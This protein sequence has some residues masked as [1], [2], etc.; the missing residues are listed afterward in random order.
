MGDGP[1]ADLPFGLDGYAGYVDASGIGVTFPAVVAKYPGA[2]HLSIATHGKLAMCADVERGAMRSWVGYPVGY[3]SVSMVNTLVAAYGR[4]HKLWTAHYDPALGAHICG[5]RTCNYGG[6]LVTAADGTQWT[7]HGGA[8]DES[9]L[10]DDFFALHPQPT[11][12]PEEDMELY[13]TNAA[14]TG[15]V[16]AADLSSKRGIPDA[17]DAS[18]LIA[19]GLYKA[20]KLDDVLIDAIPTAS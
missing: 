14:G 3:C 19:T 4:P 15:F 18:N 6:D 1:V 13:A 5:P 9:I 12:T 11:P 2:H 10:L 8:W 16:I 20:V 7:N 17:A